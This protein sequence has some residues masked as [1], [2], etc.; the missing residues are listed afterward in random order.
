M[1]ANAE[2]PVCLAIVSLF[3]FRAREQASC[4]LEDSILAEV[5]AWTPAA[6]LDEKKRA[7]AEQSRAEQSRAEQ[8]RAEQ[9]RAE[10]S[11]AEQSR[12][13]RAEQSRAEQSRED[14][15]TNPRKTTAMVRTTTRSL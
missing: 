3:R 13:E 7:A 12:A 6:G 11:R 2:L 9:S 1:S 15:T 8:S 5:I 10:Q 14:T 4:Q